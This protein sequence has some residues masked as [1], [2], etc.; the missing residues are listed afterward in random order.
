VHKASVAK[1]FEGGVAYA[2]IG[3]VMA[4]RCHETT[5]VLEVAVYLAEPLGPVYYGEEP[6]CPA[7]GVVSVHLQQFAVEA[8]DK[9]DYGFFRVLSLF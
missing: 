1:A 6:A 4:S 7:Q 9:G 3:F 2:V 8:A 5:V